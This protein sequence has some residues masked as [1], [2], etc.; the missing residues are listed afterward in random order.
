VTSEVASA[1]AERRTDARR[2]ATACAWGGGAALAVLAWY[3]LRGGVGLF[4]RVPT[5]DFYEAQARSLLHGHWDGPADAYSFERFRVGGRFYTYFGPW[6]ALPRLP[7]VALFGHGLDGRLSRVSMIVACGVALAALSRL[8]WQART[9]VLGDRRPGPV[10]LVIAGA[11][12]FAAACGSTLIF[13]AGWTAVYH[14]AIAWGVAWALVSTTFL[15]AHVAGDRRR[16]L[17][18]AGAAAAASV[19]SRG[20]VGFGPIAAIG[21]VLAA[22]LLPEISRRV[23]PSADHHRGSGSGIRWATVLVAAACLVGPVVLYAA[24]NLAKFGSPLALPPYGKQDQL[25][26]LANR[27]R[28]LAANHGSLFG[29]RY[30]P[31]ILLQY[32]RPDGIGFDRLFPWITFSSPPRVLGGAVFETRNFSVSTVAA[33][34]LLVL[35]AV[36]GAVA[37]I[38]EQARI[39]LAPLA[40]GLVG[41]F[42][43]VSLAFVDQRYQG[44]F[45][46]FLLPAAVLGLWVVVAAALRWRHRAARV[47]VVLVLVAAG[48]WGCWANG[49]VSF[50]YQRA[51][52]AD[53]TTAEQGAFVDLQLRVQEAVGAGLPSRVLRG[54]APTAVATAGTLSVEGD[55]DAVLWSDGRAWHTVEQTA[56]AGLY[57]LTVRSDPSIPVGV[58]EPLLATSDTTGTGVVWLVR[59]DATHIRFSYAWQPTGGSP[60][61]IGEPG[62]VVGFDPG[63]ELRLAVDLDRLGI[64]G[65]HASV[66]QGDRD[67]L[68]VPGPIAV[69]SWSPGSQTGL[70]GSTAFPGTVRLEPDQ[71]PVCDRLRALGLKG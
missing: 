69:A 50:A 23:G 1:G 55:C 47:G 42:G 21:L 43:A 52:R 9:A 34:P 29:L 19:L 58:R 22:R 60:V 59:T 16:D 49:A 41:C 51:Y 45:L 10:E 40:G 27:Q 8:S 14:E 26:E 12:V 65:P 35:F 53:A 57:R 15:V 33:A 36:L 25:V 48:L 67:I 30:A 32:L 4:D 71:T 56:R 37:S 54:P 44:D 17:V 7:F 62:F 31:T 13:L 66:R 3:A 63:A 70:P 6:P 5:G 61:D 20:S 38:R 68:D 2:F 18:C 28:A 11:S 64:F 24:V 46:P 39:F